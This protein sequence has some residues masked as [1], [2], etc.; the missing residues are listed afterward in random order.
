MPKLNRA[1]PAA[2]MNDAPYMMCDGDA[3]RIGY[4]ADAGL[5]LYGYGLHALGI[6]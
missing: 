4:A 3:A 1:R 5:L 2:Y 6:C